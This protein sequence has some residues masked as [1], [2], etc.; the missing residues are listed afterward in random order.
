MREHVF[1][2]M[3][4]SVLENTYD[5]SLLQGLFI[6]IDFKTCMADLWF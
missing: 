5:L 1:V 6:L 3:S 4:F 2:S